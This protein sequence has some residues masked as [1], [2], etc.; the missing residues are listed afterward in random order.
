MTG[1]K[2]LT[3]VEAARRL[4]VGLDYLYGLLWTGKL[5]GQKVGRRWLIPNSAV[6]ARLRARQMGQT[7]KDQ[8]P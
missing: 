1:E 5:R 6:E 7:Q 8:T 3:A 4:S 2:K